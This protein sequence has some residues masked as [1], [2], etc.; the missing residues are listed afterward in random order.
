M[1][2]TSA[3][4]FS[5]EKADKDRLE[6]ERMLSE[7]CT[8]D[9]LEQK[10]LDWFESKKFTLTGTGAGKVYSSSNNKIISK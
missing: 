1:K 8:A 2:I 4:I 6:A 5:D 3:H 10:T 7:H 9:T